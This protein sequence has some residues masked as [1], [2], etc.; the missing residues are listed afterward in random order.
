KLLVGKKITIFPGNHATSSF[1]QKEVPGGTDHLDGELTVR[2][3]IPIEFLEMNGH[4]P[5]EI[6]GERWLFR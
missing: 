3:A 6:G 5:V 2:Q 1:T 4:T